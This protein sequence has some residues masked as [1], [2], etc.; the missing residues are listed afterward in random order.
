MKWA[1]KGS[2][3]K[4]KL[5]IDNSQ[6]KVMITVFWD[7]EGIIFIDAL[8]RNA[9]INKEKYCLSL[10]KLRRAIKTKR[11]DL[12][13]SKIKFYQDNARPLTAHMSLNKIASYGWTLMRYPAYSPDLAPSDFY[14]F[15]RLK[16]FLRGKQFISD[17]NIISE[18]KRWLKNKE[19]AFY[20]TALVT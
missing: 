15:G 1:H 18:V 7:Q 5:K 10:E 17:E 19:A 2:P 9:T 14:L 11:P 4:K 3:L 20:Q 12:G 16:T 13:D 8:E 6:D